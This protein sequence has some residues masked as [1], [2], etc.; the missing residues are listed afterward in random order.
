[1]KTRTRLLSKMN[2]TSFTHYSRPSRAGPGGAEPGGAASS[3][4]LE[5][6]I[7]LNATVSIVWI[8]S[9]ES[10]IGGIFTAGL[11]TKTPPRFDE[12]VAYLSC[13]T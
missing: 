13:C 8:K 10:S 1:M 9:L 4:L 7:G 5:T 3:A 11:T 6:P 12:L 2:E